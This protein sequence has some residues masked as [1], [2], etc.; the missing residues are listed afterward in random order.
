M[1]ANCLTAGEKKNRKGKSLTRQEN[2]GAL[3]RNRQRLK[4][5]PGVYQQRQAI[6]EHSF[7]TIKRSWGGYYTLL[8]GLEK[9]DGEYNLLA[10]CYNIRRSITEIG[11]LGLIERLKARSRAILDD[12]VSWCCPVSVSTVRWCDASG[13]RWV[14][15]ACLRLVG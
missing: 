4:D 3:E 6:V 1:G 11:V 9:V 14:E 8:Q 7:G 2:A 15:V 5:H 13:C 10:C 12:F